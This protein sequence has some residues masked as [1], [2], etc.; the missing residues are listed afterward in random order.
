[1]RTALVPPL[2]P[3]VPRWGNPITRSL[4]RLL[5]RMFRWRITGSVPDVP[6]LVAIA[7]PHTCSFDVF[8]GIAVIL[9]LGARIRWFAKHT[10]FRWGLGGPLR[11]LGGISVNRLTPT[12]AVRDAIALITRED[13]MFL[14][15]APEGTRR[16]VR[17]WKTGFYRIA[18]AARVP[19]VPVA[20]DY[21][22]RAV[23]IGEPLTPTGDYAT[24][25]ARLKA[26][27]HPG[28]ARHPER[29]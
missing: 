18:M 1:V 11:W 20:L 13:R 10:T 21:S 12:A 24:D 9:A 26:S 4:G 22:R 2:G 29:F 7:A 8:V 17:E 5:L 27:F 6:K 15:L 16:K 3:A 28:M 14:A 25:L 23:N 19:I